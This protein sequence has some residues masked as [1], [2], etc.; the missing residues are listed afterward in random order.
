LRSPAR[1]RTSHDELKRRLG[2]YGVVTLHRPANVDDAA[3]L[4]GIVSALSQI[5]RDLP[6]VFPV[7]PRTAQRLRS[8]G[9]KLPPGIVTVPPL[10]YLDFLGLWSDA[11]VVL[12]D[13]GGLQEE[14]T[15][16]GVRCIT[17]RDSTERP[18]TV[19]RGT[20]RLAGTTTAGI[21]AAFHAVP[22]RVRPEPIPL[23]D[24]R[25]AHRVIAAICDHFAIAKRI[26]AAA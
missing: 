19:E 5:S 13:S 25:A 20:N 8:A 16:L 4:G 2:R 14:T 24:G 21:L 18:V 6:L 12:T 3:T 10:P 23:W 26:E 7:H 1:P 22:E 9:M 15:A 17:L 11:D